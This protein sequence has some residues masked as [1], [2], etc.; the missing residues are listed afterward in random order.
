M[1]IKMMILKGDNHDI[2]E[3]VIMTEVMTMMGI[4]LVLMMIMVVTKMM[5][6]MGS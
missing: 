1:T 4:I 5:T 6:M 2:Y 3:R